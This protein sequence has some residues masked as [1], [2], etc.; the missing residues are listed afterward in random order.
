MPI[1]LSLLSALNITS[2]LLA[3]EHQLLITSVKLLAHLGK[4]LFVF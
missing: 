1:L 2:F 3:E 4:N